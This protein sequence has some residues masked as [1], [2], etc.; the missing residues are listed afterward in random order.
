MI[1]RY[2]PH[3][4]DIEGVAHALSP[5]FS[6]GRLDDLD[7]ASNDCADDADDDDE[8]DP[9]RGTVMMRHA[10]FLLVVVDCPFLAY[11]SFI[12]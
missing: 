10:P 12:L 2:S 1:L 5:A 7:A 3:E 9:G 8:I 4:M 11:L 6:E